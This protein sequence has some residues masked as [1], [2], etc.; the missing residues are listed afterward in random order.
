M[1]LL[2]TIYVVV[3]PKAECIF[4]PQM[5]GRLRQRASSQSEGA[6]EIEA[7]VV[8]EGA[9]ECGL[10][11]HRGQHWSIAQRTVRMHRDTK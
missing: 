10:Q 6:P 3:P 9:P 1:L 2:G 11:V 8:L 4:P 5:T 7:P